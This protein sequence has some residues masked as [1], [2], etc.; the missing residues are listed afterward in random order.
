MGAIPLIVLKIIKV[1]HVPY[2]TVPI[3]VNGEV[4]WGKAH[5]KM[6]VRKHNEQNER[7]CVMMKPY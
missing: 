4:D 5:H 1:K 6:H 2:C 7:N 3:S